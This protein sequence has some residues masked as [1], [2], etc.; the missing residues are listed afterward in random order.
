[1]TE[2]PVRVLLTIYSDVNEWDLPDEYY[3][4]IENHWATNPTPLY[5]SWPLIACP[6]NVGDEV[7]FS[8]LLQCD[9]IVERFEYTFSRRNGITVFVVLIPDGESRALDLDELLYAADEGFLFE[10]ESSIADVLREAGLK[11][12]H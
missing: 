9:Y 12:G 10:N 2:V 11:H 8:N 3:A 7:S 5:I 6:K 4:A 1:M